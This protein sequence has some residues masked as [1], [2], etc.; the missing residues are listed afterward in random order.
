MK[1][2]RNLQNLKVFESSL[3]KNTAVYTLT[4]VINSAIPFLLI[5]IL[6]RYLSPSDYGII[7]VYTVLVAIVSPFIGYNVYSNFTS[8][9]CSEEKVKI[10]SHIG[11][12]IYILL[13]STIIA[14]FLIYLTIDWI[15][16]QTQIPPFWVWSAI[17]LAFNQF[18]IQIPLTIWQAKSKSFFFGV[19]QI[20]STLINFSITLFLVVLYNKN[21]IGRIEAQIY[22]SV[23]FS[24]L[25]FVILIKNNLIDFKINFRL[26]LS[27]IKFGAPLILHVIGGI[28]LSIINRF[29]ITK[30]V[31]L[32][33]AG[34]FFLAFQLTSI[35]NIFT[36]ALNTAYVPW[37]FS[38]L[39]LN[40]DFEKNKIVILTYKYFIFLIIASTLF[41]LTIPY[42]FELIVGK[43]FVSA[44][45]YINWLVLG[46][47]FN[48]MYLM[49]TN[50]LVYAK[51]TMLLAASTFSAAI[52]T[53]A[54][55]YVFVI[56]FSAVGAAMASAAGFAILFIFTWYFSAK[57][58][59]MPW[60]NFKKYD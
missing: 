53:V 55:N 11:N 51:R 14:V 25:A 1:F 20:S 48:G 50:Y 10:N 9:Y 36:N 59:K 30:Y 56:R 60:F 27:G 15:V 29:F 22:T 39:A 7:S 33:E 17:L 31:G 4:T 38:K 37:L 32:A 13:G 3:L 45:K 2:A 24:I 19:F 52:I 28:F 8:I 12:A 5:P 58:F 26:I 46:C 49:V 16:I 35:L 21:W 47:V 18:V 41:V 34:L 40:S 57:S 44:I 6:T 42:L 54:L 23:I 43:N